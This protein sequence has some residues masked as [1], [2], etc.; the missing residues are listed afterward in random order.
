MVRQ[1]KRHTDGFSNE[2]LVSKFHQF[3][4]NGDGQLN[5]KEFKKL[6]LNF[7]IKITDDEQETLMNRFDNDQDGCIN[8][9]EF[10]IFIENEKNNLYLDP[11]HEAEELHRKVKKDH[12]TKEEKEKEF[13]IHPP[14][15]GPKTIFLHQNRENYYVE[16][17]EFSRQN[18]PKNPPPYM[19]EWDHSPARRVRSDDSYISVINENSNPNS[20]SSRERGR[21]RGGGGGR[22]DNQDREDLYRREE[23]GK[24]QERMSERENCGENRKGIANTTNAGWS[25]VR[26]RG[27]QRQEQEQERGQEE[28]DKER[29]GRSSS[30]FSLPPSGRYVAGDNEETGYGTR[31]SNMNIAERISFEIN[32]DKYNQM[33]Q[34]KEKNLNKNKH[35]NDNIDNYNNN[36]CNYKINRKAED[37]E[38]FEYDDDTVISSEEAHWATKMLRAQAHLETRLGKNYY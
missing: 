33:N 32:D 34:S 30:A 31:N 7:G 26:Q 4:L 3:D 11:Q 23:G 13:M 19:P 16:N 5:F 35:L 15:V 8:M 22:S 10:F 20:S 14:K 18:R 2:E 36:T 25:D 27:R 1:W 24:H 29:Q 37:E 17:Q 38:E 9:I 12:E 28:N 6:L 21:E